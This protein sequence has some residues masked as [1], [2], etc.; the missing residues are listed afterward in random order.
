MNTLLWIAQILLACVFFYAGF[1]KI[2]AFRRQKAVAPTEPRFDGVGLPHELAAAIALFEIAAAL[3]LVLPVDLWQPDFLPRVA[4]AGCA[5]LA[6][7]ACVYHVR[8]KEHTAPIVAL[9]L[10]ALFVIVGRWPR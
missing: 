10:L 3:G 2:F 1:S 9:F 6:L 7:V 5:I 8:R 4:A